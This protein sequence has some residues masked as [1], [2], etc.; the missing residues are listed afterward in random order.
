L[1]NIVKHSKATKARVVLRREQDQVTLSV[2]DNGIGLSEKRGEDP[3][4]GGLGMTAIGARARYLGGS[5]KVDT[6][7]LG[8][9]L[10]E[11]QVP[12]KGTFDE[13]HSS[14]ITC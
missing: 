7:E 8:G 3:G 5:V 4:G 12:V 6:A 13:F 14:G 1:T 10:V 9:L 11:V 2:E